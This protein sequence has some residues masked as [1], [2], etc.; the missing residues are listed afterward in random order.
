[1]LFDF[2]PIVLFFAA[3]KLAGIYIA[4]GVTMAASIVQVMAFWLRYRFFEKFHFITLLLVLTLGT[5]TLLFHNAMFIKWKPTAIYWAFALVFLF[6]QFFGQKPV[7]QH[8]MGNKIQLRQSF[9]YRLNISWALFFAFM[10]FLN[11]LVVYNFSTAIWVNFKLFG[12]LGLSLVFVIVQSIY[13]ARRIDQKV[14]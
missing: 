8:L 2:F 3:Y 5:A 9:W 10:G 11:L 14:F 7:V 1:M 4:T 13:L 6:S 12:T